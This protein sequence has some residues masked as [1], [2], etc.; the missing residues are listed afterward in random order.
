MGTSVRKQ[1]SFNSLDC[2]YVYISH[3]THY[4]L[5][6]LSK[7]KHD[8]IPSSIRPHCRER[9]LENRFSTKEIK[10]SLHD[11]ELQSTWLR[12]LALRLVGNTSTI[13]RQKSRFYF[14]YIFLHFQNVARQ[15][16]Q[17]RARAQCAMKSIRRR[18][19]TLCMHRPPQK[20][21][22]YGATLFTFHSIIFLI[23]LR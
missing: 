18:H 3:F 4:T 7:C 15:G 13:T 11:M 9:W 2:W 17:E 10:F 16:A 22:A 14:H 19:Q 20:A 5:S 1:R 23:T 6:L 21:S 12:I 8:V